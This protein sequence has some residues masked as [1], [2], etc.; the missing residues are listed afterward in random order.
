MQRTRA[1]QRYFVFASA[2]YVAL[3]LIIIGRAA[4]AHSLVIVIFGIVLVAL[5]AVRL[6]DFRRWR[7]NP[8]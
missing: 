1:R 7:R 5:G 3:G 6:R 2:M 4:F 8:Q